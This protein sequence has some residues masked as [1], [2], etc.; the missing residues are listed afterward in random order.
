MFVELT[1]WVTLAAPAF[2]VFL[3]QNDHPGD[4][5]LQRLRQH[6]VQLLNQIRGEL[7]LCEQWVALRMLISNC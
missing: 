5:N 4:P 2:I 3:R 7:I 1:L 6:A